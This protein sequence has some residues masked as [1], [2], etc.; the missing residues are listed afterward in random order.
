MHGGQHCECRLIFLFYFLCLETYQASSL[1]IISIEFVYLIL[2]V[3][4]Y[5]AELEVTESAAKS[6]FDAT[7]WRFLNIAFPTEILFAIYEN[8]Y[9]GLVF[10]VRD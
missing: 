1:P 9:G 5:K 10:T 3:R 6:A 8:K 7:R 4:K 2:Q